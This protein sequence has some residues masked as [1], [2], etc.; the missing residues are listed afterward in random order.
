MLIRALGKCFEIRKA[1]GQF[2]REVKFLPVENIMWRS[3]YCPQQ[4]FTSDASM[5]LWISYFFFEMA[6][7]KSQLHGIKARLGEQERWAIPVCVRASGGRSMALWV[8][9]S[10][11]EPGALTELEVAFVSQGLECWCPC[12]WLRAEH[13]FWNFH[14]CQN[15][16][17]SLSKSRSESVCWPKWRAI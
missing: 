12:C 11:R 5:C 15:G 9:L 10:N 13:K 17:C 1:L 3:G 14:T 8:A 2:L 4:F 16:L 7:S 6:F